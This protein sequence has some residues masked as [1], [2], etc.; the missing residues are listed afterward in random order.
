MT[1]YIGGRLVP[2][3]LAAG[4][5]VRALA[6]NPDRLRGRPWF[7]AIE[8]AAVDVG[9]P[10]RL[11]TALDG[12]DVAYYLVHSMGGAD[13]F[14]QRDR[15]LALGLG[16]AAREAGVGRIVDLGGLAS[17]IEDLSPHLAS[18]QEVGAILLASGVPTAV[19]RAAVVLGSGSASFEMMR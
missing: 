12:T 16:R 17:D 8:V 14:A 11:R 5:R 2:E 18:R 6:R 3:L 4:Y 19:L 7:D 13:R 15:A 1:G 9:D 10:E